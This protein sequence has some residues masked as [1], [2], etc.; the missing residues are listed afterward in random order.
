MLP[1]R[2]Y[3]NNFCFTFSCTDVKR[4]GSLDPMMEMERYLG[5]KERPTITP[6]KTVDVKR[7]VSPGGILSYCSTTGRHSTKSK[8]STNPINR[9]EIKTSNEYWV[10][11][12]QLCFKETVECCNGCIV[13]MYYNKGINVW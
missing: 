5:V 10:N 7:V 13:I 8:S 2:N 6:E 12:L 3:L 11:Q 4:K 9:K 1:L